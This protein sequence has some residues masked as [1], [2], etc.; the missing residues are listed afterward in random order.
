MSKITDYPED[1]N[2]TGDDFMVTVDMGSG[3][4]KKVKLSSLAALYAT[5]TGT[6]TL[7]N[8]RVS[9]RVAITTTSSTP[10]PNVDT[11]D[12]Y[13]L[14]ALASDATFGVP[15]GTPSEGDTII[16]RIKADSS[17]HNLTYNAIYRA[18]GCTL[19]TTITASQ[20]VYIAFVYNNAETKWDCPGSIARS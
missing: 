7:T 20:I 11:T 9:K 3:N 1:T 12:E 14:T 6:Q 17:S 5:L 8:T 19:P 16:F 13:I 4:T 15:T 2:P 10:T 18:L